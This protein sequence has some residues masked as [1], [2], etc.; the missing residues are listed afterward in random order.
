MRLDPVQLVVHQG[1]LSVLHVKTLVPRINVFCTTWRILLAAA[2]LYR[3]L[4]GL[5][6]GALGISC[7]KL[8]EHVF[9]FK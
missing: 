6:I 4:P 5:F 7:D 1:L 2:L 8:V 9:E 3:I